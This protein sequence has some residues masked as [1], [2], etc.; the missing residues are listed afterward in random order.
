MK[1]MFMLVT[2]L[3]LG[4]ILIGTATVMAGGDKNRG[5]IGVGETHENNC[6]DQPCFEDAPM[7]GPTT[8]TTSAAPSV[9]E[10][11]DETGFLR[12]LFPR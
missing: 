11:L 8:L 4:T 7:P 3:A 9:V 2:V 12:L 6:E 1:K 10:E 5:E